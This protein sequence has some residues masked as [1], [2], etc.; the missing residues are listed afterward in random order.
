MS[1][2]LALGYLLVHSSALVELREE[3]IANSRLGGHSMRLYK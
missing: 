1:Q 3:G 2:T